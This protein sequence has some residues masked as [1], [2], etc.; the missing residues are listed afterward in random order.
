MNPPLDVLYEDAGLLALNKPAGLL[1]VP[2][3]WDKA[4]DNLMGL[5]QAARPGHYLANVHRLDRQTTGVFLVAKSRDAFRSLTRQLRERQTRKLYVALVHGDATGQVIDLPIGP[6]PKLVGRSRV[7]HK[8]GKPARSTVRVLEHFHGYTLIEV[9]IETGRQ[10]QVRVH[11]HAVGHPLVGD[12][13]YGG[14]PLLLSQLK[15]KYKPKDGEVERPLISRPALHAGSVTLADPPVTITASL[16]KDF[17]VS[18][19]YLRRFAT[20]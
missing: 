17:E 7:D 2:D 14:G 9:E 8:N 16:P 20:A 5:L 19:K 13:D 1:A 18:L 15:R 6:H 10:H 11:C 3:R 12:A 4:K